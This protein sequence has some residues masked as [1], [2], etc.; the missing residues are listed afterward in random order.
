M[1]N[2]KARGSKKHPLAQKVTAPS[3]EGCR[4][5]D[6]I[7]ERLEAGEAALKL[8]VAKLEA[9]AAANMS[10]SSK[11]PSADWARGPAKG[12]ERGARPPGKQKGAPGAHLLKV[13]KPDEI[14]ELRPASCQS[15]G[16]SLKGTLETEYAARQ[17]HE[18]PPTH[19]LVTEHRAFLYRCECGAVTAA[20]FPT[21]VDAPAQYGPRFKAFAAWLSCQQHLPARRAAE[22]LN[23]TFGANVS[24]ASV[25]TW[26][27]EL[28]LRW[29]APAT[30]AITSALRKSEIL[31]ADETGARVNGKLAWTHCLSTSDL[32][33]YGSHRKRGAEGMLATGVLGGH[34]GVLVHDGWSAYRRFGGTH[35]LCNA[36]HLR[37]LN[38]LEE[39][40]QR[41]A[42]RMREALLGA[43]REVEATPG[44]RL[45]PT[46]RGQVTRRYR[47][48]LAAGKRYLR[49]AGTRDPLG[50]RKAKNL[51]RR[52]TVYEADV[53]RFARDP[54]VPFTNNLAERDIRMCKL[55][56]KVS[57]GWRTEA[58]ASDFL[59]TRGYLSTLRKNGVNPLRGLERAFVGNPWLPRA[60][61]KS[62]HE[63]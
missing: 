6:T 32:T 35:A 7:I 12:R 17:T 34:T 10:N 23:V 8:R 55:Q 41:W 60:P 45:S 1:K 57:G 39:R 52:L 50:A 30:A 27:R 51:L 28:A 56:Q 49:Y 9:S 14:I 46:R 11:S 58:G 48:A 24:P 33:L 31:H 26:Q 19:L 16:L 42:A 15:C 25:L 21:G 44:K 5:R 43:L 36:H 2:H 13:S 3:C 22:V 59:T 62:L 54:R 38:A 37:E 53:L 29:L 61:A 47:K 40:G 4:Q 63:G 20:E 18:L